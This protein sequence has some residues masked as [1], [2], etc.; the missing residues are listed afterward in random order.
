M[1]TFQYESNVFD[2]FQNLIDQLY[3][4]LFHS[5]DSEHLRRKLNATVFGVLMNVSS[6]SNIVYKKLHLM[7]DTE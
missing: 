1:V 7:L 3:K 4:V 5:H 2:N 6:T